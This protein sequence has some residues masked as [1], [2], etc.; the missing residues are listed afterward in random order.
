MGKEIEATLQY[1]LVTPEFQV[2]SRTFVTCRS[3]TRHPVL[4]VLDLEVFLEYIVAQHILQAAFSHLGLVVTDHLLETHADG[5][6][7][8]P[9]QRLLGPGGVGPAHLRVV[10]GHRL[11]HNLN[12]TRALD[13]VVVLHLLDDLADELGELANGELITVSDVHGARFVRVHEGDE[14]VDEIVDVLERARLFAVPIHGH[15]LALEG[16]ND[17]IR[18]DASVVGVHLQISISVHDIC[19]YTGMKLTSG[20]VSVEDTRNAHVDAI[21]TLEAVG[22]GFSDTFTFIIASARADWVDMTPAV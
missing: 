8:L 19:G 3:F 1:K 21:L 16:L 18:N 14:A 22:E 17:E 13:T 20:T 7:G 11:V 9:L 5:P 10:G 15:V 4:E 2:P 6:S 12:T